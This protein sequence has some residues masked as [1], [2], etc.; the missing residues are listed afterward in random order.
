VVASFLTPLRSLFII[1]PTLYSEFNNRSSWY[2]IT[3]L[4]NH[5][6]CLLVWWYQ[7]ITFVCEREIREMNLCV[8]VSF[9]Q[10]LLTIFTWQRPT[11]N[12]TGYSHALTLICLQVY[13]KSVGSHTVWGLNLSICFGGSC[14]LHCECDRI[15]FM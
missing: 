3:K 1:I 15:W 9:L 14:C 10:L 5:Y 7:W 6:I 12:C 8:L 4:T 2:C 13:T 11:D